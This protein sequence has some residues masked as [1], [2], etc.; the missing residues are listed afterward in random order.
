MKLSAIYLNIY[1]FIDL[2]LKSS[3][4][5]CQVIIKKKT[6]CNLL[7]LSLKS[8]FYECHV[9]IKKSTVICCFFQIQILSLKKLCQYLRKTP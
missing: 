2:S 7:F 4:Y 3:F 1:Y 5:E 6:H 9:I 8:I